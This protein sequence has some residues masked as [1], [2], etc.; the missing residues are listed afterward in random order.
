MGWPETYQKLE[1]ARNVSDAASQVLDLSH[2]ELVA[3]LEVVGISDG[4]NLLARLKG[5][6]TD[7]SK[8]RVVRLRGAQEQIAV[9]MSALEE[10]KR[11]LAV[12]GHADEAETRETSARLVETAR[13][14]ASHA[15]R[16]RDMERMCAPEGP[17]WSPRAGAGPTGRSA[18]GAGAS[19]ARE[20]RPSASAPIVGAVSWL[21]PPPSD[22]DATRPKDLEAVFAMFNGYFNAVDMNNQIFAKFSHD[23]GLIDAKYARA[24]V[25]LV[26][27]KVAAK[28]RRVDFPA[29][30]AML[31]H[32]A[33]CK[34][35]PRQ[36]LDDHVLR[37]ARVEITGTRGSSRFFDDRSNW[38]GVA[39][40]GG[41]SA[42]DPKITLASM[43]ST[44][45]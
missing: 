27:T 23:C 8:A 36:E 22:G 13:S 6:P 21:R 30:L 26:W 17:V 38:T 15:E 12:C 40:Q 39:K 9:Q 33:L 7:D 20:L 18:A 25:D 37:H 32:I 42:H 43:T 31:D 5:Q 35:M 29:F 34:Q 16:L 28:K 19:G 44:G 10:R 11:A 24:N 1:S 41:P 14:L 2:G 3:L 45:R 4:P